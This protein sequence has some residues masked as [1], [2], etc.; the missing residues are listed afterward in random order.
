MKTVDNILVQLNETL[1]SAKFG[2]NDVLDGPVERKAS[3]L[4]NLTV[5]GRAVTNVIQ[6]LKN[7][8][9]GFDEWYAP[10]QDEM[11]NDELLRFFYERRSL[12]LKEGAVK[13]ARKAYIADLSELQKIPKPKNAKG[14]FMGDENGGSGWIVQGENGKEEKVYVEVPP[15]L[16]HSSSEFIDPPSIHLGKKIDDTSIENLCKLYYAYFDYLVSKTIKKFKN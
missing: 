9:D 8:T 12:H 14:F 2:L 1:Q 16:G 13:V 15:E 3:G 11:R 7:I 5:W 4:K 6:N 10:I